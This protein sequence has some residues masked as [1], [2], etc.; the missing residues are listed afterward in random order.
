MSLTLDSSMASNDS[1]I[2]LSVQ[3]SSSEVFPKFPS[4]RERLEFSDWLIRANAFFGSKALSDVVSRPII[5]DEDRDRTDL[6][7]DDY[8][9]INLSKK[10]L[11]ELRQ[12][13]SRAYNYLIQSLQK[14]QLALISHIPPGDAY[15]VMKTLKDNYGIIKSTTSIMSL[16]TKLHLNRKSPNETMNDFISRI[17][18]MMA[19]VR[20]LDPNIMTDNMKKYF[21]ISGL[22]NSDDHDW[23]FT[24]QLVSSLD[25]DNTWTIDRLQQY[26]IDQEEK[27]I[28]KQSSSSSSAPT[29]RTKHVEV[30][31]NTSDDTS[32]KAFNAV[33]FGS[34]FRGRSRGGRSRGR[35]NYHHNNIRSQFDSSSYP[36][37]TTSS[38]QSRGRINQR[39]RGN[40]RYFIHHRSSQPNSPYND[41]SSSTSS[42]NANVKCYS[43]NK[44]GHT[45]SQCWNNPS[46]NVQCFTCNKYGHT[47]STCY[48]NQ[49][50][51]PLNTQYANMSSSTPFTSASIPSDTS[52]YIVE[53]RQK[54]FAYLTLSTSSSTPLSSAFHTAAV[55]SNEFIIDSGATD[56]YCCNLT[57]MHDITTLS[58]P[59]TIITANGTSTCTTIGKV[60]ITINDHQRMTLSDVLYVP[61]FRVNLLS[62]IKITALGA[63]V[64]YTTDSAHIVRNGE[65]EVTFPRRHNMYV[66]SPSPTQ[67]TGPNVGR[68]GVTFDHAPDIRGITYMIAKA[69]D[70]RLHQSYLSTSNSTTSSPMNALASDPSLSSS[71]ASSSSL[72][73]SHHDR[74]AKTSSITSSTLH[75]TRP[76]IPSL[77]NNTERIAK[78]IFELHLKHGHVNFARLI[79]MI[80][81]K[82]IIINHSVN[83]SNE[84]AIIRQ[85][86]SMPCIGCVKGKMKR[87][88]M[89]GT[90]D[91]HIES[92]MDMLV[93]DTLIPIVATISGSKYITLVMDVFTT[94]V[95]VALHRSKDDITPYLINLIKQLQTQLNTILKRLHSDNGTEV[96]NATMRTFLDNQGTVH[97]TS[98]PY[99][100]EHN[101][102]IERKIRTIIEMVKSVMHHAGAYLG[103]YGEAFVCSGYILNRTINTRN[104]D[105]TPYEVR[106]HRKPNTTHFHV[107]GCDVYYLLDKHKRE[108]KFD[109][110]AIIGIFVGYDANNDRYYRIFNVDEEKIIISYNCVFHDDRFTEMKRLCDIK[111]NEE[112]DIN[113]SNNVL[114]NSMK[115]NIDDFLP[116]SFFRSSNAIAGMFGDERTMITND[117]VSRMNNE[118]DRSSIRDNRIRR[119]A[120]EH[121]TVVNSIDETNDT[122]PISRR[123]IQDAD[124]NIIDNEDEDAM[125]EDVVENESDEDY[126]DDT[127]SGENNFNVNVNED[128]TRTFRRSSRSTARPVRYGALARSTSHPFRMDPNDYALLVLDEPI[129]YKQAIECDDRHKWQIAIQDELDAHVKNNTWTIVDRTNNM[130]VIGCKW[131]FKKKRDSQGNVVKYKAR[132]VAKGYNQQY[133]IDFRDTF[134]PVLKYKSLRIILI[135]SVIHNRRIEQLDVK[136][137]FLNACVKEDIYVTIPEGMNDV[138]D[139]HVMKLNKALYGIKQ[140]PREWHA[141]IDGYLHSIGYTSCRKDSCIYWKKSNTH[142]I[143]IIGLFVDD[144]LSSYSIV[145][146]REWQRDKMLLKNKYEM[147]ELGD[148]QHILGMKVTRT[149]NSISITQQTYI[150]DKLELF[151]FTNAK[152][153]ST[154]EV[155]SKL[156]ISGESS[157]PFTAEDVNTYR[158]IVGSLIY[159]SISTRPDITHAVN[160]VSRRMSN[161][162]HDSTMMAK[163]ILRYLSGTRTLGLHYNN[164]NQHQGGEIELIGY[165]DAD[166]G[167]NLTDRKSTTGYCTMMNGNLVSWQ[168]KKQATVALSSAEAQYMAISDVA[169]EII[170]VDENATW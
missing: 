34:G 94:E 3:S 21:I 117:N 149:S 18:R 157:T 61:D 80:K 52:S 40:G 20:L 87:S 169:K 122:Q 29:H 55:D 97:T 162:S 163:R 98:T 111:K 99:T 92:I 66:L 91:Y 93:F 42:S 138:S 89:T 8:I 10:E 4:S 131:V 1:S 148:V 70:Q 33:R 166:W 140:A 135:F 108:N 165:C 48:R 85:L 63:D 130:N 101:S 7:P 152:P 153:M 17:E 12:K 83:I 38:F 110:N 47:S 160:M 6:S 81:N 168:S 72:S 133:G 50:K 124:M 37:S 112:D 115:A 62:V 125:N 25:V 26:L 78:I 107:W 27:R 82:N 118:N 77:N 151:G 58:T 154:P 32:S 24:A 59:R 144:I 51:R 158:M 9:G 56:H 100:P 14:K 84:A 19:D 44:P 88:A 104:E 129:S 95:F 71:S 116:D 134:A 36:S 128:G 143:I 159:A 74:S 119:D 109:T 145:D 43:C 90:I 28:L 170:I 31:D 141:E 123:H 150:D 146:E 75:Q 164:N 161:P 16:L 121:T 105:R 155:I 156:S 2:S 30:D 103:L 22:T 11:A 79:K 65:I 23:K 137:A 126:H 86:R 167:G 76:V 132:L 67:Y 54:M 49:R 45:S 41:R 64:I 57:L 142:D 69:N 106:T 113:L 102:L 147:T 39:G 60:I 139:S 127:M 136:T 114:L 5:T 73:T 46:S 96:K 53:K 68:K 120:D 15:S 13:A 35:S